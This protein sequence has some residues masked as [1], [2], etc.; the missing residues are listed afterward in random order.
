MEKTITSR[1]KQFFMRVWAAA[2][3]AIF[4]SKVLAQG[5][6]TEYGVPI[7]TKYGVPLDQPLYGV[8]QP[9]Y[10][11]QPIISP[12]PTPVDFHN[13]PVAPM[14]GVPVTPEYMTSEKIL[15]YIIV[16]IVILAV[17]IVGTIV[18]LKRKKKNENTEKDIQKRGS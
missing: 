11:V 8:P 12:T 6:Q 15:V 2:L 18:Y 14:Y 13:L 17:F 7:Q 4:S 16:P 3:M 10:G 1:I 5:F 9:L